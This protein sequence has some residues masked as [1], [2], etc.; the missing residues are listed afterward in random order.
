MNLAGQIRTR[1][2]SW[3]PLGRRTP[4]LPGLD[5]EIEPGQRVLVAGA[6]GCGKS[7]LLRALAG[8]LAEN[9]PGTLGGEV[10]IDGRPVTPGDGRVG[11]L[12]QDPDDA[13]V[14]GRVGRDVAFG[15]ENLGVPRQ[16]LRARIDEA[17]VAVGFPYGVEHPTGALSGGEAQRLA[18][19]GVLAMRPGVLLLDEPTSMLDDGCAE[20]VRSAV[21]TVCRER[22]TT[23]VVVEHRLAGWVDIVDRLIVLGA[24]GR[25][26]ADGPARETL[27]ERADELLAAGVW[28]PGYPAPV[29]TQIDPA[30]FTPTRPTR[31]G[32]LLLEACGLGL[33]RRPRRGLAVSRRPPT[34][35]PALV[36][37]DL[38]VRAGQMHALRG[39]S[40]AGKS[41]LLSVLIGL[42]SATSGQVRAHPALAGELPEAPARWTSRKLAARMAWVPQRAE[43]TIAGGTVLDSLLATSRAL[44][45]DADEASAR[46]EHLLDLLGLSGTQQRH[47]QTLSGGQTRRLAL[48][49]ALLHG[50]QV[51]ALDEPTVGQD[52]LV[53]GVVAGLALS[54]AQADAAVLLSTHDPDLAEH[55]DVTT[56]LHD[57]RVVVADAGEVRRRSGSGAIR[58][59]EDTITNGGGH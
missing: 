57:G 11:L 30:L 21:Q 51:L 39:V 53:W 56:H 14:A 48:A 4:V 6:G 5:L 19:A 40:G 22:G 2:L 35:R 32:E 36:D 12:L 29:P 16:E 38:A 10:F 7:T 55:V 50:P 54:C 18:L 42:D 43:L 47:P 27:T 15:P 34:P 3:T 24:D 28:V 20:T 44:E 45:F 41:T 8:V 33:T 58:T 31:A 13:R 23:L 46:A 25:V 52:R 49:S 26:L 17:L 59:A 1:E 9:E 37:V